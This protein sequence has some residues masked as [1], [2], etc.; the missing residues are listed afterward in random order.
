MDVTVSSTW[1]VEPGQYVYL[2]LPRA[3]LRIAS[4]LPLF[5]VSS[6]DDTPGANGIGASTSEPVHLPGQRAQT[7]ASEQSA[8][9][10]DT[11]SEAETLVPDNTS[12][13]SEKELGFCILW[14]CG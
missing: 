9:Q 10:G 5:Y 13:R 4:Q 2:W 8:S 3:G 14:I 7:H 1:D 11:L 12:L 6:W